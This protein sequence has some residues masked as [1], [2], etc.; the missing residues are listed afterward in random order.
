MD[1]IL[2][3]VNHIIIS[4]ICIRQKHALSSVD[5]NDRI[6]YVVD[7]TATRGSH[8]AKKSTTYSSSDLSPFCRNKKNE[9]TFLVAAVQLTAHFLL[10]ISQSN[11]L[12]DSFSYP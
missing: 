10:E 1:A 9:S 7:S 2:L 6:K 11:S 8:S 12:G 3:Y 5:Y 4:I